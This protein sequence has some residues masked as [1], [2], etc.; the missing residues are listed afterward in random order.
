[1]SKI[2]LRRVYEAPTEQDG[3]R[4][5]VDR[6]WPRGV[7]KRAARLN[8]WAKELGPSGELRK[9]FDHRPD[10]W[11]AFAAKYRREL[12]TPLRQTLLAAVQSAASHKTITLVYG[13]RDTEQN[14]AVI[15]S[16]YLAAHKSRIPNY[17]DMPTTLLIAVSI[18]AAASPDAAASRSALTLLAPSSLPRREI[19]NALATL[20]ETGDL[21]K[22]AVGWGVTSR[23][24]HQLRVLPTILNAHSA[25]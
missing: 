21:Q 19:D 8:S 6:L 9:W 12:A 18:A 5:L 20:V 2:L 13:A 24:K 14:E 3:V 11:N 16:K 23:G 4:I 15:L 7:S 1:M 25:S 22:S 17:F 10:R